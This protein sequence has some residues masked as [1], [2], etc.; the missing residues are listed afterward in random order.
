MCVRERKWEKKLYVK[1]AKVSFSL[2][3]CTSSL[4]IIRK[5]TNKKKETS[6]VSPPP[7]GPPLQHYDTSLLLFVLSASLS[8]SSLRSLD[9]IGGCRLSDPGLGG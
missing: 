2:S 8:L 4:P 1:C 9:A 5:Q 3:C 6:I 7:L